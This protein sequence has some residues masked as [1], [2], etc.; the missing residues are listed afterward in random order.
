MT[1][2][3]AEQAATVLCQSASVLR[4]IQMPSLPWAEL[5]LPDRLLPLVLT[6]RAGEG[7]LVLLGAA[8]AGARYLS[9]SRSGLS[10]MCCASMNLWESFARRSAR[11][12]F[13]RST[14]KTRMVLDA[15][16]TALIVA[17]GPM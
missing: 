13:M 9:A 4:D 5:V 8:E 11:E 2:L 10:W 16:W 15:S 7:R 17:V 6:P 1:F 14:R 12:V 3:P